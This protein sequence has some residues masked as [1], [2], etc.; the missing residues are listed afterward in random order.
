[1][2]GECLFAVPL[3]GTTAGKPRA[4]FARDYGRIRSVA[5]APDGNLWMTTSNTDGRGDPGGEDDLILRVTL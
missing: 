2:R 4:Y 3:N 5:A 1:L